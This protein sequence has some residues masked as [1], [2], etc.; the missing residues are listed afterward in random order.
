M[1]LCIV[2]GCSNRRD[3]DIAFYGMRLTLRATSL[4]DCKEDVEEP[5]AEQDVATQTDLTS[6][7]IDSTREE[8]VGCHWVI[9]DLAARLT[10]RVAFS[11]ASFQNDETVRFY[12]GLPN[13]AIL[14][15]VFA[16]V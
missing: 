16:F 11:E 1:V 14:Q 15:A 9:R 3:K 5:V 6:T 13:L 12:T 4:S 7:C 8:L 10:Q 2:I